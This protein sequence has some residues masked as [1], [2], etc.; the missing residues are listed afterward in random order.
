VITLYPGTPYWDNSVCIGEPLYRYET[1][2]DALYSENIDF[3]KETAYYKGT[4]GHY[5]AFVWT[6]NLSRERLAQLRDQVEDE[7]RKGLGI[8][9]P[10]AVAAIAFEH[11]MGMNLPSN[12]LRSAV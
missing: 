12:I 4:P 10:T 5:K 7:V 3:T 2:G 11:S 1:N 8:P 9:Y 6:D